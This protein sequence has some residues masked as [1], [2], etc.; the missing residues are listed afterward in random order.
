MPSHERFFQLI[1]IPAIIIFCAG[2]LVK[3][4]TAYYKDG[5]LI[6][7]PSQI[8][9]TYVKKQLVFDLISIFSI[10]IYETL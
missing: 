4:N 6:I 5:I 3:L 2:I 8:R 9:S 1:N 10:I 7:E